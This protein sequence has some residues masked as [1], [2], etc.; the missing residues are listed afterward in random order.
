MNEPTEE[1]VRH[2]VAIG[3]GGFSDGGQT[4]PI[5]HFVMSLAKKE[6][7][8]VCFIPTASGDSEGYI[9][10]FYSAFESASYQ[11]THLPLFNRPDPEELEKIVHCSDVIYVGGGNTANLLAIWSLHAVP[12]LLRAAYVRG[13]VMAGVSAGGMCWFKSGLTDSFGPSMK[14]LTNGMAFL[15]DAF[16]PHFDS[17]VVRRQRFQDELSHHQANGWGVEDGVALHFVNEQFRGAVSS[18]GKKAYR[19]Q[20]AD[21]KLNE[22]PIQSH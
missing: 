19:F 18:S 4:T 16:C 9:S 8:R 1:R 21:G 6:R 3:G 14:F 10:S 13:V 17:E 2:I 12:E 15:P 7:P 22:T 20:F 5:D 11:A